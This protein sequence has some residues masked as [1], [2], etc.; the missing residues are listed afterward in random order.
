[1]PRTQYA[2]P[3]TDEQIAAYLAHTCEVNVDEN[4]EQIFPCISCGRD[5]GPDGCDDTECPNY[6]N[7]V[8]AGYCD[9]HGFAR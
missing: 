9:R 2:Y 3:P 7:A 4:S 1:M 8:I 5:L 6:K